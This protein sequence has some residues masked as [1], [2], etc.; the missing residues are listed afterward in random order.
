MV[1]VK[2]TY[3][4]SHDTTIWYME[5]PTHI[6]IHFKLKYN[7]Y[8]SLVLSILT[9]GCEAWSISTEMQKKLQA[10]ENKSHRKLL[11]IKYQEK[12]KNMIKEKI[13]IAIIGKYDPL[14]RMIKRRKIKWHGHISR[15]DGLRKTIMQGIIA[16]AGSS[17]E[18]M[19]RQYI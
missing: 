18:S 7:L 19:D 3:D 5:Q 11:G 4:F 8:R 15:H 10:F 14:L 6:C 9:Y 16:K 12:K 13:A 17:E 2:L 1:H